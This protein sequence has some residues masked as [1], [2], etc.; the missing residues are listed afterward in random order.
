MALD[1]TSSW[2]E[3]KRATSRNGA[4]HDMCW[5]LSVDRILRNHKIDADQW[6]LPEIGR[7]FSSKPASFVYS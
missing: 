1:P 4:R 6:E 3:V 7:N 5:S 2:S